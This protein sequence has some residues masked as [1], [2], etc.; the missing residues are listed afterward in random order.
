MDRSVWDE[1]FSARFARHEEELAALFAQLYHDDRQA[2]EY[3]T[4]MLWRARQE[5][6]AALRE[7]DAAREADPAWYKGHELMGMLMYVSSFAGTLEGVREKLDYIE[8]CGVNYLHLMPLL[9]SP[10]GR[11]DGGYAVSDFR[12]ARPRRASGRRCSSAP[13]RRVPWTAS[14]SR[15]R[16]VC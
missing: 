8:D 4:E 6:P 16:S 15:R 3:F 7:L 2:W 13:W 1:V 12:K 10:V 11:S 5:R 14:F 9:E